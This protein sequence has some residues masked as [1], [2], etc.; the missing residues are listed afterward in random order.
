MKKQT[1]TMTKVRWITLA[2]AVVLLVSLP[3]WGGEYIKNILTLIL[4]YLAI[5]EMWNLLAGYAGLV[6]LGAQALSDLA[7]TRLR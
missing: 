3:F 5:G 6:S 4:M 2:V 7:G 1:G